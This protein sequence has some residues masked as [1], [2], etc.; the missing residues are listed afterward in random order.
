MNGMAPAIR[1]LLSIRTIAAEAKLIKDDIIARAQL[2]SAA[3]RPFLYASKV[4][5]KFPPPLLPDYPPDL[6]FCL[7][8][9]RAGPAVDQ[10]HPLRWPA[11]R[12][13]GCR[14]DF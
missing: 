10:Y 1:G 4:C 13:A 5:V 3:G 7:A 2:L 6:L 12:S 14:H 9:C 8:E 11:C